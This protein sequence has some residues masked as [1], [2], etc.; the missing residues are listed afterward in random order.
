MADPA[1]VKRALARLARGEAS[2]QERPV[3]A[4]AV[5]AVED[6]PAAAAFAESGGVERLRETLAAQSS[7]DPAGERA[8]RAFERYRAACHFHSGHGRDLRGHR[9]EKGD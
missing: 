4:R 2:P 3:V 5:A 9:K 7:P 6:L 1:A 8:L